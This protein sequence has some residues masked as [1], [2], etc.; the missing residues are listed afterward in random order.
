MA[1]ERLSDIL[2]DGRVKPPSPSPPPPDAEGE[3]VGPC[4]MV[5][6]K[7]CRALDVDR[8]GDSPVI[9]LQ[10]VYISVEAEFTPEKFWVLFVGLTSWKV[11]VE[12]RNLRPLFDRINDHCLRRI[13]K[14][15]RDFSDKEKPLVTGLEVQD[16]T[17]KDHH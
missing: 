1:G 5:W 11:T 7:G 17:P 6:A 12:G 9:S 14:A 8:G 13:R 10:Y 15:D 16:V 4:G 2:N 3:D